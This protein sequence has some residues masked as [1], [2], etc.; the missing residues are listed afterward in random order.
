[1]AL[2]FHLRKCYAD[3][4][5]PDGRVFIGY[6]AELGLGPF[7]LPYQAALHG[8]RGTPLTQ[9]WSITRRGFPAPEA[10]GT[11]WTSR[12]LSLDAAWSPTSA[13]VRRT[14][15][16]T[17]SLTVEWL[18]H[19]PRATA[20]LSLEGE[21]WEGLGYVEELRLRGDPAALPLARLRWG[22]LLTSASWAV[23]IQW[24]GPRPL[25][26]VVVDGVEEADARVTDDGVVWSGGSLRL[27]GEGAWSLREERADA[28]AFPTARWLRPL[29]PRSLAGLREHKFAG[30][31]VLAAGGAPPAEG[32]A[33]WERVDW[34]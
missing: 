25:T 6:A 12:A 2:T 5:T 33:V 26:L 20:R 28:A 15:L 3:C 17:R 22:R 4:V 16:E 23:W 21:S 31:G 29:L 18:C 8:D 9:R 19:H 24:E 7:A 13:P 32:W 1:M 30:P 11:R 10:R 34:P 27:G 14:L